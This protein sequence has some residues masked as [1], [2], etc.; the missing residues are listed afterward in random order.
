MVLKPCIDGTDRR[1]HP[2]LKPRNIQYGT[3]QSAR[4]DGTYLYGLHVLD[5]GESRKERLTVVEGWYID[6][7]ASASDHIRRGYKMMFRNKAE[8]E[9]YAIRLIKEGVVELDME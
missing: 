4:S 5:L 1:T 2:A 7:T 8:R 6:S 3:Y 9:S